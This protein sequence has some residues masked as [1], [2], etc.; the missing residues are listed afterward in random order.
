MTIQEFEKQR[1][2]NPCLH[3]GQ[4]GL[5]ARRN[6]NNNGLQV[7]CPN[8]QSG[9]PW[10]SLLY[11][12][13]NE[14]KR[15]TRPPLPDGA[16]LDSIW[17]K[18]DNRC[19]MCGAPKSALAALGIGRQVHHVVPYAAEGHRGPLVPICSHCHP[20]VTE[21]QRV[22]WFY[23]RVVMKAAERRFDHDRSEGIGAE[24][25]VGTEGSG[26]AFSVIRSHVVLTSR[27]I[28]CRAPK[29]EHRSIRRQFLAR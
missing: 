19:V 9:R 5:T 1:D 15:Q 10:G 27:P 29:A 2:A 24:T 12:K 4:P 16:T 18:Y 11:L 3:C 25:T 7:F 17:E 23:R 20:V 26:R 14:G 28:L 21:R 8:C 6:L 13:Q 22:Y